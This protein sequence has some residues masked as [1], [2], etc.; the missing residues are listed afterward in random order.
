MGIDLKGAWVAGLQVAIT[1]QW[2]AMMAWKIVLTGMHCEQECE[3]V[4]EDQQLQVSFV[5]LP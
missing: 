2:T 3:W 5:G 1:A 4:I